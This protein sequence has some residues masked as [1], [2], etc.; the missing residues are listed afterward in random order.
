[1]IFLEIIEKFTKGKC[2][3]RNSDDCL[4]L[5]ENFVAVIDGVTAKG[6]FTLNNK[7]TGCLAAELV[8][9]ALDQLDADADLDCILHHLEKVF[10]DFYHSHTFEEDKQQF[11]PQA[12][13]VLYSQ[14]KRCIYLIGDCQCLVD[15][16]HYT[17][18]KASDL[19]LAQLRSLLLHITQE[20]QG[21]NQITDL[22][23]KDLQAARQHIEGIILRSTCFANKNC[24]T[25]GY[26][27]INGEKI[28]HEL[29]QVIALDSGSHEIVL[30]SD[31]YPQLLPTLQASEAALQELLHSD[32]QCADANPQT[33]GLACGAESF[34]DRSY[35]RLS[36]P[37]LSPNQ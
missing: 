24:P 21:F 7:S 20:E 29:V 31:G 28:P 19:I 14:A 15:G 9:Q 1:M 26:A 5:G 6:H 18:P 3:N 23:P 30:A 25:W 11:G 27:V 33:K 32:P 8:T 2:P 34:D 12:V 22:A 16:V 35:I 17:A 10:Q 13:M 4:Y 37:A 36:I